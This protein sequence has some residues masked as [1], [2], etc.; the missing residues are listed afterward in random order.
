MK[1]WRP[2]ETLGDRVRTARA[3]KRL[4]LRDAAEQIGRSPSFLSDIEH[5]RRFPSEDVARDL[6]K[7]LELDPDDLMAASGR[8][9]TDVAAYLKTMPDAA[10]LF[11]TLSTRGVD[12]AGVKALI[13]QA[14]H[15]GEPATD[16]SHRRH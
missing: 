8:L 11:R 4:T 7:L 14:E 2:E 6:A 1:D 15:L 13:D 16:A 12:S 3:R 9:P 10:R 5:N